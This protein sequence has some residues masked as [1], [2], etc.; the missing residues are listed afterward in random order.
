MT[1]QTA[2]TLHTPRLRVSGWV[3]ALGSEVFR[4]M[5]VMTVD[6]AAAGVVA[7]VVQNGSTQTITH[8]LLGQAPPTAVYRLISTDLLERLEENRLWLRVVIAQ[9]ATLPIHQPDC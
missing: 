6:G 2:T 5:S 8:I 1:R 7:A 3:E 9:V 4:G